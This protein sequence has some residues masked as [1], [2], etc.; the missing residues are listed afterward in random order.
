MD[1]LGGD[2]NDRPEEATGQSNCDA[3]RVVLYTGCPALAFGY[4]GK[5]GRELGHLGEH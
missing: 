5:H 3:R 4:C 2:E 1:T